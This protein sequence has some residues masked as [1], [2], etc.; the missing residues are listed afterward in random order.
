VVLVAYALLAGMLAWVLGRRSGPWILRL[1]EPDQQRVR[2]A[3]GLL[4][5]ALGAAGLAVLGLQLGDHGHM[6]GWAIGAAMSL[7]GV[8]YAAGLV[9]WRGGRA[10]GLR[11]CGWVLMVAAA[12][13]P[14]SLT[15]G[16]ALLALLALTLAPIPEQ[17]AQGRPAS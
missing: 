4:D 5:T 8:L 7:G 3:A 16:A 10:L 13:I 15:V 17:V 2:L 9:V 11:V 12:L 14:S 6:L 1:R